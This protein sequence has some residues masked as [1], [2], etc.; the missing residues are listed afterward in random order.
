MTTETRLH[1]HW[2]LKSPS[3]RVTQF[4]R[5]PRWHTYNPNKANESRFVYALCPEYHGFSRGERCYSL[6]LLGV[7]HALTGVVLE[8]PDEPVVDT[9]PEI[10]RTCPECGEPEAIPGEGRYCPECQDYEGH[11]HDDHCMTCGAMT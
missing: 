1:R 4:L 8:W 3:P 5:K 7:L 11:C 2:T 6:S 10:P 9:G